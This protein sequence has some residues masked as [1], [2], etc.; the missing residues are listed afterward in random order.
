MANVMQ[1]TCLFILL[2]LHQAEQKVFLTAENANKVI[3]RS[4]RANLFLFDEFLKGNLEK[5][6]LEERCSYEEAREVFEDK[7]K[8]DEFWK[9]YH[10]GRQCSSNPC[11]NQG[12]CQDT[13]RS[14]HC[15]CPSGYH[16]ENCQHANYEC[17][18]DMTEGCQHF[19]NP[20]YGH[21]TFT[22]SCANGYTLGEDERSCY[23]SDPFACGQELRM[24]FNMETGLQH[25]QTFIF[26]WEVI[27]INE[28]EEYFCSGVILN[29]IYVLTTAK[30]SKMYRSI[31][32]FAGAGIGPLEKGK[33]L[34]SVMD[35]QVHLR[36]EKK[37]GD[38]DLALLKLQVNIK[39]NKHVLPI[40]LPQ[41][42]FAENVL[43]PSKS[44]IHSI[45]NFPDDDFYGLVPFKFPATQ[46]NKET[47]ESALNMTQTNRMFC[48]ISSNT[49]D[50][51][52]AGG[53]YA[54]AKYRDTW[55][56]TG[57]MRGG[58]VTTLSQNV[59]SFT[60]ISRYILWLND[61]LSE[62]ISIL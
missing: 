29:E 50:S 23:P 38:N 42:D 45:F 47:C 6:C 37:T 49:M 54:A 46:T 1:A 48:S 27:L 2:L 19:C 17:H 8:T 22:C 56:L 30:C 53:G 14:Y 60:K 61:I 34:I 9:T 20:N 7:K 44:G 51:E 15:S 62:S 59:F 24:A 11:M 3:Q 18:A 26:P 41:K 36:Y 39:Y 21:E 13:I 10:V 4:K 52:I 55:F 58:N 16:G 28:N 57:I 25:N 5:E 43:L 35:H 31:Y 40:C 12:E 33:Q 32:V